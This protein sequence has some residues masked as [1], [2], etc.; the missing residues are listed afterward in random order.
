MLMLCPICF[1]LP[2]LRQQYH[3]GLCSGCSP[4][5]PATHPHTHTHT[6]TQTNTSLFGV[7]IPRHRVGA[8]AA[9]RV[10]RPHERPAAAFLVLRRRDSAILLRRH[11]WHGTFKCSP[12]TR[13]QREQ[14]AW[15]THL[16]RLHDLFRIDDTL[17]TASTSLAHATDKKFLLLLITILAA[18]RA[19]L[20]E[21]VERAEFG[22]LAR[23]VRQERK[24]GQPESALAGNPRTIRAARTTTRRTTSAFAAAACPPQASTSAARAGAGQAPNMVA[25][26]R[27]ARQ[28]QAR[29]K[30]A[31]FEPAASAGARNAML[32]GWRGARTIGVDRLLEEA[33][34]LVYA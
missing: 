34:R 16:R 27:A 5:P 25:P 12:V 19:G 10:A 23:Q 13:L 15:N 22:R 8:R 14:I 33:S 18:A 9:E 24:E 31:K 32:A 7:L 30:P 28:S 1:A 3:A 21:R 20:L 2:L 17:A 26:Q 6:Q 29:A 11:R 4:P